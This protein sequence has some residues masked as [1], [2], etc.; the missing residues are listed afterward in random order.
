VYERII[1]MPKLIVEIDNKLDEKF[2]KAIIA[3]HGFKK[4]VIKKA[5]E[6]AIEDWIKKPKND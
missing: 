2:R 6:E 3:T 1:V 4:G 5:L